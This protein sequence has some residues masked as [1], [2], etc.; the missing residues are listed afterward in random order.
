ML[1]SLELRVSSDV[2]T[3]FSSA[4]LLTGPG[5]ARVDSIFRTA[6]DVTLMSRPLLVLSKVTDKPSQC[7]VPERITQYGVRGTCIDKR[8]GV[9][10]YE[11][12]RP[13][14]SK[15]RSVLPAVEEIKA[16]VD[17]IFECP[18]RFW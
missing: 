14:P 2:S 17:G 10:S 12:T 11:L 4:E 8:T 15:L 13:L 5:F 6:S 3:E 18:S 9:S 1:P 7:G 16:E